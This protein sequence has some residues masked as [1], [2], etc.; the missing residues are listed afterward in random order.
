LVA[1][2]RERGV[3][4]LAPSDASGPPLD[5]AT[6]IARLAAHADPRLRAALTGLFL[7]QPHLAEALKQAEAQLGAQARNELVARYMAAVYLQR[8]WRTR[9]SLCLG[10]TTELPDYFS[11]ALELPPAVAGFGKPGLHALAEWHQAHSRMPYDR[12]SEY[13]QVSQHI[14]ARLEAGVGPREPAFAR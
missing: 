11:Q 7:L 5:D 2:L 10:D 14:F 9:L 4:W 3:D 13:M 8:Y 12:L 6:L 1:A